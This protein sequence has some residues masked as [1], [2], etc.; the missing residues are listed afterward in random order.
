M[1]IREN[2]P[3]II[4]DSSAVAH[5]V[6]Y[7]LKD[8]G[9]EFY[10]T[11]IIFGFMS[12]MFQIAKKFKSNRFI[13]T[14]DGNRNNYLR[15]KIYPGYKVKDPSE[16][17]EEDIKLNQLCYEQLTILGKEV[18]PTIGFQNIYRK[19]GYEADDIIAN[20]IINNDQ[21]NYIINSNDQDLYQL[22]NYA[23]LYKPNDK[24][25]TRVD[26]LKEWDINPKHWY[27]VKAIAGCKSDK[28][29]GIYGIGEKKAI[30][31]LKNKCSTS[32]KEKIEGSK[33]QIKLYSKLTRLPL[34][35]MKPITI[36]Y[37]EILD[38]GGFIDI[39]SRFAFDSFM[40]NGALEK[41]T[42]CFK[43]NSKVY[44]NCPF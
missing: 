3:I 4:I 27:K 31:Y 42:S 22:L 6:K 33:E 12:K 7:T 25:Y 38:L 16:M 30:S 20:I 40:N 35:G 19:K 44:T 34:A 17:P 43:L 5:R 9:T 36:K 37:G 28:I 24:L 39:C 8:L 14:F 11:G 29:P 32:V 41:W 26:F 2:A 23:Q 1:Q 21:H 13:F 15:K 18:L 10:D